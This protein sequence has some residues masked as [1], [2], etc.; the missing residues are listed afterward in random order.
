MSCCV[1]FGGA[2]YIGTHLAKHF[3]KT[4]RF[5]HI[6]I[7][8]IR[9]SSLEGMPGITTSITDVR[10][11]IPIGLVPEQPEWIFNLA[12]VHREP[13]HEPW[14][15]YDTNLNG[16]HSACVYADT[17]GCDNIFF[18]SSLSVYGPTLKPTDENCPKHPT[19]PYGG[20]KY[21]AEFIHRQWYANKRGRRLLV[22]RPG[23]LYGPGDPGNIMRM[24]K[25]I[26]QGYFAYPGS[27]SVH[28]SYGY[29]FGFINSVDFVMDS[30]QSTVTYNYS[31]NPTQ[32]LKELVACIK[33]HLR[34]RAI[35]FPI[36]LWVLLPIATLVQKIWG[37]RNPVH[38]VRVRKAGT[39]THIVPQK[40]VDMGFDFKY[41]FLRSLEHWCSVAPE[42]FEFA[43]I[44][45]DSV[46]T[47]TIVPQTLVRSPEKQEI[48]ERTLE[49]VEK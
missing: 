35:S 27:P 12:A 47:P 10:Q 28:K 23:V 3:L 9:P 15:Y 44:K 46:A 42:D 33:K 16:A 22:T 31:E 36:P 18:T 26:N 20:S 6:H 34:C 25:A 43:G 8:D 40:L 39:S 1:I 19:T 17:V 5:T 24:I 2:G 37:S 13:G 41:D 30:G 21:P 29:I 14:E 7:A 11:P 48:P 38:P 32:P 45:P 4:G 49:T